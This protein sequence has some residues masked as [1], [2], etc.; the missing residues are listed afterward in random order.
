[1]FKLT[2]VTFYSIRPRSRGLSCSTWWTAGTN[3]RHR[4]RTWFEYDTSGS[5]CQRLCHSSEHGRDDDSAVADHRGRLLSHHRR[6]YNY[7]FRTGK[8]LLEF[9]IGWLMQDSWVLVYVFYCFLS[10]LK[11]A[12]RV[13]LKARTVIKKLVNRKALYKKRLKKNYVLD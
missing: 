6:V 9:Q 1:M 11:K 4:S 5:N 10:L 3:S 2:K 12:N 7:I 13:I 8:K